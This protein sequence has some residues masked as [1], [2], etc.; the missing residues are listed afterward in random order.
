[1]INPKAENALFSVKNQRKKTAI[2]KHQKNGVIL[3]PFVRGIL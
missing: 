1:M 2:P 3:N